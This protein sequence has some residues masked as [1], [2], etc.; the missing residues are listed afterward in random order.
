M[1]NFITV[2]R[3]LLTPVFVYLVFTPYRLVAVLV[4]VG[5]T[6]TDWLDGLVSRTIGEI[7]DFGKLADP[8]A[9]RILVLSAGLAIYL[10]YQALIPLWVVLIIAGREVLLSL[11]YVFMLKKKNV[12][13][14]V[15]WLG[16]TATAIIFLS[17]ILLLLYPSAGL[18]VLYI[19]V[20]LYLL[21]GLDYLVKAVK[22]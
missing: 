2:I 18:V 12:K 4:L 19:G 21:A 10:R 20:I 3:F 17:L 8:L 13:M 7:T 6:L 22:M 5:A 14:E 9:D 15:S 16:K 1:A 11:G